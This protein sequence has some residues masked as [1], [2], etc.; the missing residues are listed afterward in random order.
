[1]Y[2]VISQPSGDSVGLIAAKARLAKQ[3]H[4]IPRLELISGHM[5]TNLIVNVKEAQEGFPVGEMFCWLDSSVALHWIKG[6]GSY[7]QFVSNR[8]QKIQQH[9]EVKW[10]HVGTKDNPAD[11]S[12]WSRSIENG[13]LWWR[14]PEWLLDRERWPADIKTTATPESQAEAKVIREVFAVAQAKTDILDALLVKFSL[15]KTLR[16]CS[17]MARFI[18]NLRGDKARKI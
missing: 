11:L 6:A 18:R 8:V 15:C 17:W 3:G 10:R 7:K 16:V 13:E 12:S 2:G 1:M 4:T 9:P 5:A 14:G